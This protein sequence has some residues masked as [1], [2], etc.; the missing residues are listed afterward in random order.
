MNLSSYI[1][2]VE[3]SQQ[4]FY[5]NLT[6][7]LYYYIRTFGT[8]VYQ[9]TYIVRHVIEYT[10]T[11]I[12]LCTCSWLKKKR[13]EKGKKKERK[14]EN[15]KI[16]TN[17][18]F[19]CIIFCHFYYTIVLILLYDIWFVHIIEHISTRIYIHTADW[20]KE[21]RKKSDI[22]IIINVIFFIYYTLLILLH[23]CDNFIVL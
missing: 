21:K 3:T 4:T 7:V 23:D 16:I 9:T 14:K 20:K 17:I 10:I 8:R 22:K 11:R 6:N 18:I 19:L 13:K 2:N 15:I 1:L 12:Y 5:R